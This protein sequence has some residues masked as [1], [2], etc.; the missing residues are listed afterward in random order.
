LLLAAPLICGGQSQAS[1]F[2]EGDGAELVEGICTGCHRANQIT[3]SSGYTA[4]HWKTLIGTMIDL[5]ST[6]AEQT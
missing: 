3:R 5:S 2:P 4:D 6:P 1:D